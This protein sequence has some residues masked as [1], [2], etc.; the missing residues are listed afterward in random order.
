LNIRGETAVGLFMLSALIIFLLM[1][2]KIGLWRIDTMKY[3]QYSICFSDVSGLNEKAEVVISG[4]KVGWVQKLTLINRGKAVKVEIM[5]DKNSIIYGNGSGSIKQNGLLGTKYVDIYP[6]DP[7]NQVLPIG[8]MLSS[9]DKS[10]ASIDDI[11][12]T[13]KVIAENINK[14]TEKLRSIIG[15]GDE[16]SGITN[17]ITDAREAFL[18]IKETSRTTNELIEKNKEMIEKIINDTASTMHEVK[19]NLPS[20]IESFNTSAKVITNN[21]SRAVDSI[22]NTLTPIKNAVNSF[23]NSSGILKSIIGD[24][25]LSYELKETIN[26]IKE[27]FSYIDRLAIDVDTHIESMQGIGNDLDFKDAK[28][29]FN[30]MIRPANDF[31]YLVG[32]TSSYAGNVKRYRVDRTWYD[33]EKHEIIPNDLDLNGWAKLQYAPVKE[34]YERDYSAITINAQFAKEFGRLNCR[35]GLFESTFGV[36]IDYDLPLTDETKWVMSFEL[37]RFNEFMAQTLGGRMVFDIDM[38]H[39]KWYNRVFVN[40]SIY[41]MFGADDFISEFNKNFFLGIGLT[42]AQDDIKYIAPNINLT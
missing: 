39:L 15:E 14:V 40:D 30:F 7:S 5:I 21:V 4:V 16:E 22:E 20:T 11:F 9:P 24:E 19:N 37:Y 13:F 1:S 41:F 10:T 26:N 23:N 38:P 2:F 33:Q 29:Y 35:M 27:Y 36:G 32:L 25:N 31:Y 12:N 42:F 18:S 6:G 3:A 28:G 8:S 17:V 34:K